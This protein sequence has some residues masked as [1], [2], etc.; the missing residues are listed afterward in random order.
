MILLRTAYRTRSLIE[1]QL[2]RIM[3]AARCVSAVLLLIPR[4]AAASLLVFPSANSFRTSRCRGVRRL[5]DDSISAD[6][7]IL[8]REPSRTI[9][10]IWGEKKVLLCR[11]AS[12]AETRSRAA[13]VLRTYPRTPAS[14]ISRIRVSD[15]CIVRIRI[16]VFDPLFAICLAASKPLT[17][18]IW[19]SSTATSGFVLRTFSTASLPLAAS[20][21]TF[22]PTCCSSKS[23]SPLLTRS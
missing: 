23:R 14:S 21:T 7:F 4:A 3:R 12:T 1:W 11:R 18:G 6:F 20:A 17:I 5:A 10:C 2:R 15:S 13:S 19:I 8:F 22:H 16:R 9:S